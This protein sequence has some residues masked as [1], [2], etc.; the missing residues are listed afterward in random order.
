MS[1]QDAPT[2]AAVDSIV[3]RLLGLRGSPP[4]TLASL[5]ENEIRMLC[6]EVRFGAFVMMVYVRLTPTS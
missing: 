1:E 3:A 5:A 6:T 4:G 2:E